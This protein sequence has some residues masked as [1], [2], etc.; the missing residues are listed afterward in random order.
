VYQDVVDDTNKR[1]NIE[2]QAEKDPSLYKWKGL[3]DQP[4][5]DVLQLHIPQETITTIQDR[6]V[7]NINITPE[8]RDV[9]FR[10]MP[11]G[12]RVKSLQR[13]RPVEPPVTNEQAQ[14]WGF[15]PAVKDAVQNAAAVAARKVVHD[16]VPPPNAQ[17]K[18]ASSIYRKLVADSL[19]EAARTADEYLRRSPAFNDQFSRAPARAG[20]HETTQAGS[21]HEQARRNPTPHK[22]TNASQPLQTSENIVVPP[23]GSS[24][25]KSIK[26]SVQG[27]LAAGLYSPSQYSGMGNSAASVIDLKSP[28]RATTQGS[29]SYEQPMDVEKQFRKNANK[30][31]AQNRSTRDQPGVWNSFGT[32]RHKSGYVPIP[33]TETAPEGRRFHDHFCGNHSNTI[34]SRKTSLDQIINKAS[35][36]LRSVSSMASL[37]SG[38]GIQALRKS[39]HVPSSDRKELSTMR[40]V[41]EV[42]QDKFDKR[43]TVHWLRG[44]LVDDGP[45]AARY[46]ALPQH[47]QLDT[48]T[49]AKLTKSQT[50]SPPV[51]R[52]LLDLPT[53]PDIA[54]GKRNDRNSS[55]ARISETFTRTIDDLENL[56]NEALHIARIAATK[57][58][59]EHIPALLEDAATL[60]HQ[61]RIEPVDSLNTYKDNKSFKRM[62]NNASFDSIH[63]SARSDLS[64]SLDSL[65]YT[66]SE[67]G[68]SDVEHGGD[69]NFETQI[70]GSPE[71]WIAAGGSQSRTLISPPKTT[72]LLHP[73]QT[74]GIIV[75]VSDNLDVPDQEVL[76][77]EIEHYNANTAFLSSSPPVELGA[78]EVPLNTDE[79]PPDAAL[80][81]NGKNS[82]DLIGASRPGNL[83]NKKEVNDFIRAF[84][85]PPIAPRG[86][87]LTSSSLVRRR[88]NTGG[89]QDQKIPGI[90]FSSLVVEG[91][92]FTIRTLSSFQ[93]DGPVQSDASE[94][95]HFGTPNGLQQN[96]AGT[97]SGSGGKYEL[98]ETVAKKGLHL[99]NS[100]PKHLVATKGHHRLLDLRG[101]S[102]ISLEGNHHHGFS[103]SRTHKRQPIARDW[104]TG[105]K[106]FVASVSCISTA[107]IG[108]VA[109][110]YAGEVPSIQYY[111]A[112]LNHYA[113]LGN[114]VFFI[115]LSLPVFLLWPLPLLHGR[116]PYVMGSLTIAMPLLFPQ[117]VVTGVQ[118]S[119]DEAIWRAGLLVP[120]AAMGLA[121]G[122]A[123]MNFM[124]TLLDLF[125]A[126]LQSANPH[127]EVVDEFDVRR[128]GGGMGVWLGLW[129][130]C[131]CASIGIGFHIGAWI[132]DTL[133]PDWGF[134]VG[135]VIIAVVLLLNVVTPEVRR[136]AYRKSVAEIRTATEITRRLAKGEVKMHRVQSG[137]AWFGE[138][139]YH[140][141]LLSLEMLRQPG[142]LIMVLYV[143]WIYAQ[144][145]LVVVVGYLLFILGIPSDPNSS[146]GPSRPKSTR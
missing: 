15:V 73:M 57:E 142:F 58:N 71:P 2:D 127:Q 97:K 25:P 36:K 98:T 122:L 66:A 68:Q 75:D 89:L 141:I 40:M 52:L 29:T 136:S 79:M 45:Y 129:T 35:Q 59:S 144:I 138:E 43:R 10:H 51:A 99:T 83:P 16:V 115:A 74:A 95:I 106:R 33:E 60:L 103:M 53:K 116:K 27:T 92:R 62:G 137:P 102:H 6:A 67:D 80:P 7:N 56:M 1:G 100:R 37:R 94:M 139:V 46:T 17:H 133:S 111:I 123:Q 131:Y 113:I 26:Q 118:R 145:V 135:I 9:I 19:T 70:V 105:R 5:I 110:I 14:Y 108:I 28:P 93:S 18:D 21:V 119:P 121:L 63:E 82:R 49:K 55:G 107:M 41:R 22:L 50:A 47:N 85:Q 69:E 20:L 13:N 64:G 44:V 112:D 38:S 12:V 76:P 72:I 77:L 101:K 24:S 3:L 114:V 65:S 120:R 42:Q 61:G 109:G 130:W 146:S 134:Y 48:S 30:H 32:V 128:H 124:N 140:G 132:I 54:K 31:A 23:R 34:V 88:T 90:Q 126:S 87:S 143:S 96:T 11:P 91:D 39:P 81:Q 86:S 104:S 78:R 125:G 8:Q 4:H 84:N 117:A